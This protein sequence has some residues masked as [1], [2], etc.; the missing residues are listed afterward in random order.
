MSFADYKEKLDVRNI[1]YDDVLHL[2]KGWRRSEG[3]LKEKNKELNDLRE[4]FKQLQES[5]IKFRGQIQALESVKELTISLQAQ[6]SMYH[7]ENLQL[8]NE[9]NELNQLNQKLEFALNEKTNSSNARG[10]ILH[11]VQNDYASLKGRYE[12]M[13]ISH[14]A[15]ETLANEEK[16]LRQSL[17]CR[18]KITEERSESLRNENKIMKE[19]S[20]NMIN[21]LGQC[22]QELA[23]ASQQLQNLSL[24]VTDMIETK[25]LISTYEAENNIYKTDISRLIRLLEFYPAAKKFL[26]KWQENEGL[27]FTGLESGFG[28][29]KSLNRNSTDQ[30]NNIEYN[31]LLDEDNEEIDD[32][33]NDWK[34][35][36]ITAN[37]L[38]HLKRVHRNNDPYPMTANY[39]EEMESWVP[40]A[41][42][43]EGA[44][45]M[46]Q[47]L[48]HAPKAVI[49][50]FLR[51]MNQI[52]IRREKRKIKKV[53]TLF[54]QSII[55]LKR[56]LSQTRPYRG[57]I[58]EK[59]IKRL[60][61]QVDKERLKH[62][63]GRPK[64]KF[65]DFYDDFDDFDVAD[66]IDI[67]SLPPHHRRPCMEAKRLYEN[68]KH[69][70]KLLTN[71]N[72][73]QVSTKKLLQAS[74]HSLEL[75]SRQQKSAFGLN[76]TTDNYSN[77]SHPTDSYLKGALWLGRNLS[78]LVE[79][80]TQLLG[81]VRNQYLS[82]LSFAS[83]DNDLRRKSHRL[84]LLAA[85]CVN[86]VLTHTQRCQNRARE[87]LQGTAAITPGDLRSYQ[88]FLQKLPIES[89]LGLSSPEGSPA[90]RP[91]SR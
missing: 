29:N 53:R 91:S 52:W 26:I 22:D 47:H 79:E 4:R 66:E 40:R 44:Q 88:T 45:F 86:E 90:R 75:I 30:H 69:P 19:K 89:S 55:D 18:L 23:Q 11:D 64:S 50:D 87:M 41:A 31:N 62:L 7:Q 38:T 6:L 1:D 13:S 76:D 60:K 78:F 16:T 51:A 57:V 49:M 35:V 83:Q 81:N 68:C 43:V 21:Q 32:E 14:K 39:D 33:E 63:T 54:E 61:S 9:N 59:Q 85:S 17:E 70:K 67:S 77:N 56:Q 8:N 65:E 15:L 84:N 5:H 3:L 46:S 12:E 10:K 42:A 2:F 37:D 58:A 80:L 72:L 20:D 27:S 73:E 74:L 71:N 28:V 24:E 36:G 82:E 25:E 48:P 34:D